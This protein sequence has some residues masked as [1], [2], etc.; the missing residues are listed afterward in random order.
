MKAILLYSG[1]KDSSLVAHLLKLLGYEFKCVTANFG[2]VPDCAEVAANV[3]KTLGFEHEVIQMPR[4]VLEKG[5]DMCL[6][7][8][9]GRPGINYIHHA[10]LEKVCE[11]YGKE[12]PIIA[13]G[14]RRDDKTPKITYGEMQSLE[15][16]HKIQYFCPLNG[17]SHATI[18]YLTDNLFQIE[19]IKAGAVPT[20]EYETEIREILRIR[21]EDPA[22]MFPQHHT[23]TIVKGYK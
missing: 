19:T 8:G 4:D 16:R 14:G 18:K 13:D 9:Y 12:Y 21:K 20:S 22:K 6:E 2:A 11:K 17:F 3:A 15:A 5:V 10:V 7:A 1:G 23:H